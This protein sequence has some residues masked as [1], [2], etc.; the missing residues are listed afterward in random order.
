MVLPVRVIGSA[1]QRVISKRR[2]QALKARNSKAP[3][4]GC[5]AAEAPGDEEKK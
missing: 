3:G 1:S 5:E 2:F 4:E